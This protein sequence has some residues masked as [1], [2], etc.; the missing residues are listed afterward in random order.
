MSAEA[1]RRSRLARGTIAGV[2]VARAGVASVGHR[3]AGAPSAEAQDAHEAELGR[4]LFGALNQ[5]K[6]VALKASQ[7]LA[8][9]PG[10]LPDALREQLAR[11]HYQ[12][13]PMNRAWLQN[14]L[15]CRTLRW[16]KA[17]L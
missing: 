1:P 12:A 7:L 15:K 6:G 10:L 8:S 4:I 14:T 11:A 16:A 3:L 9:E 17:S 2:A 13:T 5:L